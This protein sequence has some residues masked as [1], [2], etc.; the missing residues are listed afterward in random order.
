MPPNDLDSGSAPGQPDGVVPAPA[1]A[2]VSPDAP[3]PDAPKGDAAGDKPKG[4]APSVPEKYEFVA[5]D[6]VTFDETLL[7]DVEAFAREH[8]LPNASAQKIADMGVKL[9]AN[10][11]AT[12]QSQFQTQQTQWLEALRVDPDIGGDRYE[13]NRG[14]AS[15][16]VDTY[17]PELK[18]YLKVSG[19]E[20]HPDLIRGLHRIGQTLKEDGIPRGDGNRNAP[21]KKPFYDHPTSKHTA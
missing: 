14:I 21:A 3:S 1:P 10:F 18:D 5:P 12:L 8:S 11:V 13:E 15:L 4:D 2:P 9:Q 16:A 20:N 19:F 6:G 7:Q 17:F